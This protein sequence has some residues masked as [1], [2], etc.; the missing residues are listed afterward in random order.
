MKIISFFFWFETL[1]S[2]LLKGGKELGMGY[3]QALGRHAGSPSRQA[4]G[5]GWEESWS[6][7]QSFSLQGRARLAAQGAAE[8]G[9]ALGG[10]AAGEGGSL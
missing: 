4:L 3:P 5:D 9:R 2:P 1:S 8:R 10:G 6:F 7:P